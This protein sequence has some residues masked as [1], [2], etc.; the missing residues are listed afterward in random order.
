M[1]I[2][3]QRARSSA[4]P[5]HGR[6]LLTALALAT[7][8]TPAALAAFTMAIWRIGAD[9]RWTPAFAV[10]SGIFSHWQVWMLMA[11]VFAALA[12]LLRQYGSR[13]GE[14]FS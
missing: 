2:R 8:F 6:H 9:L 12:S 4:S 5:A 1:R 11:A 10:S 3:I 7:V 13:D 14:T